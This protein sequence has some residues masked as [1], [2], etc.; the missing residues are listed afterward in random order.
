MNIRNNIIKTGLYLSISIGILSLS[1][2][3]K[4]NNDNF[5]PPNKTS[6]QTGIKNKLIKPST[7]LMA[8]KQADKMAKIWDKD[9]VLAFIN[10]ISIAS[11]GFTVAGDAGSQWIFTYVS[12]SSQKKGLGYEIVFKGNEDVSWLET[13]SKKVATS[14]IENISM[15]SDRVILKVEGSGLKSQGGYTLETLSKEKQIL[16][17]IGVKNGTKTEIKKI[18]NLTGEFVN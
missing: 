13:E 5:E 16:W 9:A 6:V 14:N 8:K 3:E 7:A 11:D 4:A 10:G 2:C 15:D 1:G 18:D 12:P 17:F